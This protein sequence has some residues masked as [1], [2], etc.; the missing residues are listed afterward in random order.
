MF[1]SNCPLHCVYCQNEPLSSGRV[2]QAVT[3]GR[4]TEIFLELAGQGA[5]NVN[6]VTPTQYVPQILRATAAA[7]GQGLAVP[8]VYNTGGYESLETLALLAGSV[9][10][11]LTDLKYAS[12]SLAARY[13]R[14]PD[15][16]EVALAALG[17]MLAQAGDYA[18][19]EE[20]M[21]QRGVIVRHLMLPGRLEDSKAVLEAAFAVAGNRACYSLMSQYTPMPTPQ[22]AP[23][24]EELRATV[25]EDEYSELVAFA[26][27]LGIAT[28]FMQEPASADD[29]FV[30][31]FDLTGV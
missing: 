17:A 14:A 29:T 28:S 5:H 11:Y 12:P 25:T 24:F 27:D 15:Y 1:F 21:V 30:P 6:L 23:R 20:G 2:G 22:G 31:L 9:D 19:D 13:S 4:L 26:L 18:L 3:A 8:V 16:P 7:R 10:V